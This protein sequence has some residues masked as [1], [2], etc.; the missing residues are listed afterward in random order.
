MVFNHDTLDEQISPPI[1]SRVYVKFFAFAL[2]VGGYSFQLCCLGNSFTSIS[3][4]VV[5]KSVHAI[6][7]K[8]NMAI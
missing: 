8:G 2:L 6:I 3:R 5:G 7:A 1:E 4:K